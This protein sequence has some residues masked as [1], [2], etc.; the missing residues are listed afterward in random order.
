MKI[1]FAIIG[2]GTIA[3]VHAK[4]I[5][6]NKDAKLIAVRSES[7]ER[8]EEFA[9]KY[10]I[11]AYTDYEELLKDKDIQAVDIVTKNNTHAELGIKAANAKKHV[12]VEKPIDISLT[13]A[14]KLVEECK[15]NNVKLSVISQKRFDKAILLAKK[16]IDKKEFGNIEH[17][18]VKMMWHRTKEYYESSGGWRSKQNTSGGGVLMIQAIHY[19]NLLGYLFGDAESVKSELMYKYKM[20]VE[21]TA[22]AT[23][24]FKNN[25]MAEIDATVTSPKTMP[26]RI[27]I[28]C[29]KGNIL[30]YS[31]NGMHILR[32][33][34]RNFLR[35]TIN[36]IQNMIHLLYIKK[37]SIGN[38]INDFIN[39][40]KD[41]REPS[42]TGD[43]GLKTLKIVLA[44]YKSAKLKKEVKV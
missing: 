10:G 14:E 42:V 30:L 12:L 15:K 5:L 41:N 38:Q 8:A 24:N 1:G 32:V 35:S 23:I 44:L 19:I 11:K 27:E 6:K 39:S 26:D 21:D 29:V 20:E 16:I 3:D 4:A 18:T 25:I 33:Y 22:H 7:K 34:S 17:V 28:K 31:F 37:G 36:Q 43:D 40:I 13:K 9:K 2:T